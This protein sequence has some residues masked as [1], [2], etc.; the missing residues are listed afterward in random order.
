MRH[1]YGGGNFKRKN[2]GMA[3][4]TKKKNIF[5]KLFIRDKPKKDKP[6]PKKKSKMRKALEEAYRIGFR[7]GFSAS[8]KIPPGLGTKTSATAGYSQGVKN[9]REVAKHKKAIE[10]K[11]K[12]LKRSNDEKTNKKIKT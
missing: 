3:T 9:G 5:Q 1:S 11:T 12:H 4:K 8:E 2:K 7:N 6:K 10:K